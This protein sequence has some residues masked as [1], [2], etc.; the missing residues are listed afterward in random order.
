MKINE[1]S[2]VT[3]TLG[4]LKGLVKEMADKDHHYDVTIGY[5]DMANDYQEEKYH[6]TATDFVEAQSKATRV[7]NAQDRGCRKIVSVHSDLDY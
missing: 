5:I 4:Q 2:K 1:N 7:F 6:I 3:L